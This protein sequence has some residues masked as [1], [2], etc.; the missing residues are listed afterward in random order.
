MKNDITKISKAYTRVNES[1]VDDYMKKLGEIFALHGFDWNKN[2]S[3]ATMTFDNAFVF[4]FIFDEENDKVISVTFVL[5][6]YSTEVSE[7]TNPLSY[8]KININEY[9]PEDAY[10]IAIGVGR[11]TLAQV[12]GYF[13]KNFTDMERELK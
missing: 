3:T 9:T 4:N 5:E 8:E 1:Q 13:L 10:G 2:S 7:P 6:L 12:K 11:K